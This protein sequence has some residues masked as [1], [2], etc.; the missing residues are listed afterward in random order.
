MSHLSINVVGP[1][2]R[3]GL[4]KYILGEKRREMDI[5]YNIGLSVLYRD[6]LGSVCNAVGFVV[7]SP[8][9]LHSGWFL[10]SVYSG[11]DSKDNIGF[12][13]DWKAYFVVLYCYRGERL[14]IRRIKDYDEIV[15]QK[16][17]R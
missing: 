3:E 14:T 12:M 17:C 4:D 5:S 10:S 2:K 13:W 1:E 11:F 16:F 6:E 8:L 9:A 15:K 7:V